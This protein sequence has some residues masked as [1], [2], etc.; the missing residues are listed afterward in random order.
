[1][2][3]NVQET[4]DIWIFCVAYTLFMHLARGPL[5]HS[6]IQRRQFSIMSAVAKVQN[7]KCTSF[8]SESAAESEDFNGNTLTV[9]VYYYHLG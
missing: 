1:M 4:T 3:F 6:I 5:H 2:P 8:L 7:L 9:T